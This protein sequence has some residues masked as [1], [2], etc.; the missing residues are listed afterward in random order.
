MVFGGFL[1]PALRLAHTDGNKRLD[2]NAPAVT[3]PLPAALVKRRRAD[4][5]TATPTQ[6]AR[7][8]TPTTS[9]SHDGSYF[10]ARELIR[11]CP[12]C[13]MI[14]AQCPNICLGRSIH[15]PITP[16]PCNYPDLALTDT[17]RHHNRVTAVPHQVLHDSPRPT[18]A[19]QASPL[20]NPVAVS[21]MPYTPHQTCGNMT[22][23]R[24]DSHLGAQA[25]ASRTRSAR[26]DGSATS[27]THV[28]QSAPPSTLLRVK[29][30]LSFV[31]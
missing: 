3:Q 17:R 27:P 6:L 21:P 25:R 23:I 15:R 14:G 31:S 13:S 19:N 16:G 29:P 7:A 30:P 8:H 26:A 18:I 10:Q 5:G 1:R 9:I 11:A 12:P 20:P 24:I 22:T 28:T 2:H 4:F